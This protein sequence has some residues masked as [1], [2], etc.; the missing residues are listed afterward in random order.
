MTNS[1]RITQLKQRV[2]G[3][4]NYLLLKF[5]HGDW[6]AV[7]DAAADIRELEAEIKGLEHVGD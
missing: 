2:E 7:M 1:E 5:N 6:H 3:M 4:K